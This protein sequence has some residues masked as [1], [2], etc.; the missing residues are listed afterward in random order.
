M[1]SRVFGLAALWGG[2]FLVYLAT[3]IG[4]SGDSRWSIPIALSIL[5]EGNTDL[6]EY[7]PLLDPS[8]RDSVESF[9]GHLYSIFPIGA[10]LAAVPFVFVFDRVFVF[11]HAVAPGLDEWLRSKSADPSQPLSVLTFYWRVEQAI[12]SGIAAATAVLVYVCAR[13][14]LDASRSA[15]VSM[16]FAFCTSSWSIGSTALWQHGPSMFL[17]AVA[18]C[19]LL[20]A[21]DRAALSQFAAIPLALSYIVRPT[22]SVP[23][24]LFTVYVILRHRR[25]ALRYMLWA[26]PFAAA[27]LAYNLH[28][29]GALLAP[30]YLP[31]RLDD[32]SAFW[33]AMAGNLVSPARGLF[34]Y[35]PVFLFAIAGV[36]IKCKQ[37]NVSW[38]DGCVI[39]CVVSHWIVVS[40][41]AIWWGGASYGPRLF[42]DMVPFLVYL[43]LPFFAAV[44]ERNRVDGPS[45]RG[46]RAAR[47][48]L[49]AS[50]AVSLFMQYRGASSLAVWQWNHLPSEINEHP[51]RLWDWRDLQFLRR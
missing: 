29:Y 51:E 14:S 43:T 48:A 16:I 22:N 30:Y 27:F 35:S 5:R 10:S 12:A 28:I 6:D 44:T 7:R 25:W 41:F 24:A 17:L 45:R 50:I 11:V 49:A 39:A 31:Q 9:Q 42:S 40:M 3:G 2:V 19:L 38:L 13:R 18:L 34:V 33:V 23:I 21:E 32:R 4:T 47:A 20:Y 46:R 37:R 36:G 15:F 26:A 8:G 1:R